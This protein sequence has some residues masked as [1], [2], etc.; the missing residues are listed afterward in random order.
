MNSILVKSLK[1]I[2]NDQ[3][4]YDG[5]IETSS[6]WFKRATLRRE[7]I[8]K[9][10][11]NEEKNLYY[12]YDT[13][14]HEQPV[15]ESVTAFWTLW[16]GCASQEQAEKLVKISLP[17]F[18]VL[19]GLVSGTEDSRGTI[20]LDRPNRQWDY[21][22][23][24]APHQ[25]MAWRGLENYKFM[26]EARRLAYRWLYTITKSFADFNGVVP[27]KYDV[28][29]LNHLLKVEYGN[30]GIDFKFV[31]REGFGWM[32][33][34]YQVGLSYLTHHMKRALG[35]CTSPEVFFKSKTTKEIAVTKIV[36]TIDLENNK[37]VEESEA[38]VVEIISPTTN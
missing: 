10:L 5:K 7:R 23:G 22:F 8:D 15:Y 11:W 14:K 33:A 19:G 35:A 16:A 27:E 17:K 31:P 6:T 36:S 30:V 29:T 37:N 12:D 4:E 3:F 28:V 34:S 25:I 38:V 20:A 18:E 32:N 26:T 9:Y 1:K 2:Y 24:W 13:V 21:P